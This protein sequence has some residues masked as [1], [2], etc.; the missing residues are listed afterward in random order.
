MENTLKT[1]KE[2]YISKRAFARSVST[3]HSAVNRACTL[4]KVDLVDGKVDLLGKNTRAYIILQKE[5]ISRD[6]PSTS[7][8]GTDTPG[9]REDNGVPLPEVPPPA[10]CVGPRVAQSRVAF[11]NRA[12]G[13]VCKLE[14]QVRRLDLQNARS[15]IENAR[16]RGELIPRDL[17]TQILGR[18]WAI[19][20]SELVPL[21]ERHAP[22]V[23]AAVRNETNDAF[24]ALAVTQLITARVQAALSNID[25][26]VNDFIAS[27]PV[28]EGESND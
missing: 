18:W 25:R 23:V 2:R 12:E 16:V 20:S 5:R 22:D 7:G 10:A 21:G 13:E 15:E 11:S 6:L 3:Q 4:G 24:A 26:L 28:T 1:P 17:V 19:E 9:I 27:I 8:N 14:R